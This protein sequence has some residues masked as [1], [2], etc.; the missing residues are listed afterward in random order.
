[1]SAE[2]WISSDRRSVVIRQV[3]GKEI[4][5][6]NSIRAAASLYLLDVIT[7]FTSKLTSAVS[8]LEDK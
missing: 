4:Q 6:W 1:M 3:T 8:S 2:D 7:G 5:Q